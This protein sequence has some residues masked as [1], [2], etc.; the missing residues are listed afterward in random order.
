MRGTVF[1][2]SV[3]VISTTHG[4]V[5][6]EGRRV[7]P[8]SF[9]FGQYLI[10]FALLCNARFGYFLHAFDIVI[11]WRAQHGRNRRIVDGNQRGDGLG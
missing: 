3:L 5:Q 7:K 11:E 1:T 8:Y 10:G 6:K 9:V 4:N 2:T